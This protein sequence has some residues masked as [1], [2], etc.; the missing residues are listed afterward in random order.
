ME[1]GIRDTVA[2]M[3]ISMSREYQKSNASDTAVG[4]TVATPLHG[5]LDTAAQTIKRGS[6]THQGD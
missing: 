1:T 6:P 4:T 2:P 5:D 3:L